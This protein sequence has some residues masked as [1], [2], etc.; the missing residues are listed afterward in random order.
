M[1]FNKLFLLLK[2]M[3]MARINTKRAL[4]NCPYFSKLSKS[5]KVALLGDPSSVWMHEVHH[6]AIPKQST[7][8]DTRVEKKERGVQNMTHAFFDINGDEQVH[9]VSEKN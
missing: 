1:H 2:E 6:N 9:T 3:E 4:Y 7:L 5:Y 8:E